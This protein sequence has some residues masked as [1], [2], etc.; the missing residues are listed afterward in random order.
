MSDE[1]AEVPLLGGIANRGLVVRVGHTVRR[2]IRPTGA[3]TAALLRHL[4][5]VGFEGAPRYLGVDRQGRE[6]LSY[7]PGVALTPPYPTWALSD[8]AMVRVVA[9]LRRYHQAVASFDPRP[10]A[11]PTSP[12][13][14][15][16][17]ALVSHN[18]PNLDNVVFRNGEAAALIDFD[19]ASP[20]SALWDV[21]GA[22][23]LWAPLRSDRDIDDARVGQSLRR[24]RLFVD[25]YGV[26]PAD[27]TALVEA[28]GLSHDWIYDIVRLGAERGGD[29]Y[30]EYWGHGGVQRAERTRAWFAA[31][32][33]Q[34]ATALG[35]P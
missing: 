33:P 5:S 17:S 9:L 11:W 22:A 3:A 26:S 16:V 30:A 6:M 2:P 27:R 4:E 32:Q 14:P 7:I 10:Y 8:E 29:G 18:D 25:S 20:G 15:F 19:L 28:L 35:G 31:V 12:P 23:R 21:A 1:P 24:L 13:E 34:I